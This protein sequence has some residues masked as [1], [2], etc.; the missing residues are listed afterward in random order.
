MEI[1]YTASVTATG[2]RNGLI[3]SEDGIVDFEVGMPKALGGKT[4]QML[5]PELL[6][7]SGYAACFDSALQVVLK[8][9]RFKSTTSVNAKVSIGKTSEG[10]FAL[11]AILNVN[12]SD[13]DLD[14]AKEMVQIA[15]GICPYSIATKGN[16]NIELNVTNN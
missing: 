16:M 8:Q 4:D 6:F 1:L 11:S 13:M 3:K 12:I 2:G 5:N 9:N 7:A 15:H 14:K 10:G